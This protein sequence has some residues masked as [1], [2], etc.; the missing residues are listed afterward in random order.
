MIQPKVLKMRE[1]FVYSPFSKL[2][3]WIK[4]SA[5]QPQAIYSEF[6]QEHSIVW[7]EWNMGRALKP[8]DESTVAGV[9]DH[10]IVSPPRWRLQTGW[11]MGE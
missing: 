8:A 9:Q 6:P 11:D 10:K 1:Y 2:N 7:P 3:G 4:R 5:V